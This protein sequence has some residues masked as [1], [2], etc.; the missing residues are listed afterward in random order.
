MWPEVAYDD[1]CGKGFPERFGSREQDIQK[2][3]AEAQG[4]LAANRRDIRCDEVMRAFMERV[5]ALS[6]KQVKQ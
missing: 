3:A 6:R 2:L 5:A 4:M 1:G